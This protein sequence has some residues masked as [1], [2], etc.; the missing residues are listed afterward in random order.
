[1]LAVLW[2]HGGFDGR[3]MGGGKEKKTKGSNQQEK[4]M[5]WWRCCGLAGRVRVKKGR[6]TFQQSVAQGEERK[7]KYMGSDGWCLTAPMM[8]S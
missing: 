7:K 3:R 1:M 4:K 5:S 8:T 2:I 6:L